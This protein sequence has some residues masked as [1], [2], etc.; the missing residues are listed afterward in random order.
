MSK[1]SKEKTRKFGSLLSLIAM[2]AMFVVFWLAVPEFLTSS[3]GRIFAV[4]WAIIAI[5]VFIA[6]AKRVTFERKKYSL[7][8]FELVKKN[9]RTRRSARN[10]NRMMRG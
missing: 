6:H 2:T 5:I 4:S 10:A 9:M 8:Q 3:I 7:Q 1:I